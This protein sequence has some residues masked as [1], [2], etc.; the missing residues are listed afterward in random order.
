MD[1]IHLAEDLRAEPVGPPPAAITPVVLLVGV[2][3]LV[4]GLTVVAG[5]SGDALLVAPISLA[6]LG[7]VLA[8]RRWDERRQLCAAADAWI[9][10]GDAGSAGLSYGWRIDELTSRR[11]RR[12]LA[13]TVRSIV[14]E[15]SPSRLPGASP[16]NRV[17]LRPYRSELRAVADRL[18]NLDRPVSP[19]GILAVRRL[20]TGPESVLYA[21]PAN[22]DRPDRVGR[23]LVAVLDGLEVR[24]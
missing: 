21:R 20:L 3:C 2:S 4:L 16:L 8:I 17:A 14:P 11:E 1:V 12:L 22:D 15:I 5:L 9:A 24:R 13:R 19:A 7:V 23:E 10:F 6:L 18:D